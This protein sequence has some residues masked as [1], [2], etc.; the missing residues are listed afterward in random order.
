MDKKRTV[1]RRREEQI[2]VEICRGGKGKG[3]RERERERGTEA[4][5]DVAEKLLMAP[6]AMRRR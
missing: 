1:H 6:E 2:G 5:V 3:A 4:K